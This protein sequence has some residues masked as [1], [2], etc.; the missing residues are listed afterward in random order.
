MTRSTK[1]SD[2]MRVLRITTA[3]L[4][5]LTL[6]AWV[7]SCLHPIEIPLGDSTHLGWVRGFIELWLDGELPSMIFVPF[8]AI[9]V[10]LG[11]VG[12]ATF[13]RGRRRTSPVERPRCRVCGYDLRASVGRCPECGTVF[14]GDD[15]SGP[16]YTHGPSRPGLFVGAISLA[17]GAALLFYF[18]YVLRYHRFAN[19]SAAGTGACFVLGGLVLVKTSMKRILF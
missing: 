1:S 16:A 19:W 7:A 10:I 2:R 13:L 3:V 4:L 12:A 6:A 17:I 5:L 8:A 15:D 18:G 11:L 14:G 9:A